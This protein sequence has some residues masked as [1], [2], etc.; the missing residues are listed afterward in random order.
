MPAAAAAAAAAAATARAAD[1][2]SQ[3]GEIAEK[4]PIRRSRR[5]PT[6]ARIRLR[7]QPRR[8][9]LGRAEQHRERGVTHAFPRAVRVPAPEVDEGGGAEVGERHNETDLARE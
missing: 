3:N 7:R 9:Q 6:P 5:R 8:Q 2:S 1:G 4:M